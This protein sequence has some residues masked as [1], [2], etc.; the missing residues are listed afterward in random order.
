MHCDNLPRFPYK[1]VINN[2]SVEIEENSILFKCSQ[3]FTQNFV[4]NIECKKY[5]NFETKCVTTSPGL[6]Y[7]RLYDLNFFQCPRREKLLTYLQSLITELLEFCCAEGTTMHYTYG[8]GVRSYIIPGKME[9]YS[10]IKI[11][12]LRSLFPLL[13]FLFGICYKDTDC[14]SNGAK[15]LRGGWTS[16]RR[17]LWHG[18]VPGWFTHA[19]H[20]DLLQCTSISLSSKMWT[21]DFSSCI[22]ATEK[23]RRVIQGNYIHKMVEGYLKFSRFF[24]RASTVLVNAV[25]GFPSFFFSIFIKL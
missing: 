13:T 15:G 8:F 2:H 5:E 9:S 19:E 17:I 16:E 25:G 21:H 12:R 22:T 1:V 3:R 23:F 11:I 7:L 14:S 4:I 20:N 10:S 18:Q 24:E 6:R